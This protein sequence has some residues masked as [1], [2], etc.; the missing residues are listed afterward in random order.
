MDPVFTKRL[1]LNQIMTH[2]SFSISFAA[3]TE[4]SLAFSAVV[5]VVSWNLAMFKTTAPARAG[6]FLKA[7]MSAVMIQGVR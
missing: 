3:T 5:P 6:A 7:S 4:A 2:T 1:G